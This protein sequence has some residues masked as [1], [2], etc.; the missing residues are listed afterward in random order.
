MCFTAQ[1]RVRILRHH[2][3]VIQVIHE[4]Q[5]VRAVAHEAALHQKVDHHHRVVHTNH[6][7]KVKVKV[8]AEAIAA[9]LDRGAEVLHQT[10]QT[11]QTIQINRINQNTVAAVAL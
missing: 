2:V 8:A 6:V 1:D 7:V 11:N 3:Q 5:V 9:L 10:G 4:A